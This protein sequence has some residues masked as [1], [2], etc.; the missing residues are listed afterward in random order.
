MSRRVVDVWPA[1]AS[2]LSPKR[3]RG[4]AGF[5]ACASAQDIQA[6]PRGMMRVLLLC[7]VLLAL[8]GCKPKVDP[9][10]ILIGHVAP[11][12]GPDKRIGQQARQA[13]LL[14]V[15]EAN[16][17]ENRAVERRVAVLH[18]DSRGDLDAL[19]AEAVRLITVNHVVALLGGANAAE[20]ERLGHAAQPYEVALV[21]PAAVP[22]EQMA[23]NVFSVNV[24]LA[25]QGQVLA[26]FAAE[27]LK[28]KQVAV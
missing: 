23:D 8:C 10:P 13:I 21:T 2:L 9:G 11:L 7:F 22:A 19:Q 26:G 16:E 12:S 1:S 27:E 17:E 4:M 14:A 18:T 3:R 24:S 15:K 28:A 5:L 20:V 6:L 25:F